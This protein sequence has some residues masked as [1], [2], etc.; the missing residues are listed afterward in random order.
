MFLLFHFC[1]FC[2][3]SLFLSFFLSCFYVWNPFWVVLFFFVSCWNLYLFGISL[4]S[5]LFRFIIWCL[6]M[7]GSSLV[8]FFGLCCIPSRYI[9]L[10]KVPGAVWIL[11]NFERVWHCKIFSSKTLPTRYWLYFWFLLTPPPLWKIFYKSEQTRYFHF[12]VLNFV[13][14]DT[15]FYFSHYPLCPFFLI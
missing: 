5:K 6:S 8:C 15:F 7:L 4:R 9:F 12:V 3:I 2:F 10:M 11:E 13:L 14:I 1:L